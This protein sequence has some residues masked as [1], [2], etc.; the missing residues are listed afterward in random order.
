MK[1]YLNFIKE[2]KLLFNN[3]EDDELL[4]RLQDLLIEQEDINNQISYIRNILRNIYSGF[5]AGIQRNLPS[6]EA[7]CFD[8]FLV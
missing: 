8:F 6:L 4:E 3:L 2:S 1:R 7:L 5:C